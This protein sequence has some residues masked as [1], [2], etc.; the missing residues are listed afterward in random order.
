M[1][2]RN[3]SS[4]RFFDKKDG[5]E[6]MISDSP[7]EVSFNCKETEK[8]LTHSRKFSN[9]P[10]TLTLQSTPEDTKKLLDV[11]DPLRY[12]D[13]FIDIPIPKRKH[14]KR[15]IQKKWIKRYGFKHKKVKVPDVQWKIHRGKAEIV[16][17]ETNDGKNNNST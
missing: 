10:I 13:V 8:N 7:S 16:R 2:I 17:K 6:I 1:E 11:L 9:E 3:V 14:Q 15:R 12:E 4:I 5:Q